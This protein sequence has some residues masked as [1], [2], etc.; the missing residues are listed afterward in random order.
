MR[1]DPWFY[2]SGLRIISEP[3]HEASKMKHMC[4]VHSD[5]ARLGRSNCGSWGRK[6][7]ESRAGDQ[8][9]LRVEADSASSRPDCCESAVAMGNVVQQPAEAPSCGGAAPSQHLLFPWHAQRAIP[10][11]H[12]GGCH[13]EGLMSP[14]TD[15]AGGVVV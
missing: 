6:D 7:A 15:S 12:G 11:S 14:Y 3:L 13:T 8:I 2:E 1:P 10:Q 4:A 9:L 5:D